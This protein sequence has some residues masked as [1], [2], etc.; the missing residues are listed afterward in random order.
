MIR[1]RRTS[2][3]VAMLAAVSMA[4]AVRAQQMGRAAVRESASRAR[5]PDRGRDLLLG[6][7]SHSIQR[8]RSTPQRE[9]ARSVAGL[10]PLAGRLRTT[11]YRRGAPVVRMEFGEWRS[12]RR[13]EKRDPLWPG[14]PQD[15]LRHQPLRRKRL[16]R[17]ARAVSVLPAQNF[18]GQ[19]CNPLG[20]AFGGGELRN[21]NSSA[22]ILCGGSPSARN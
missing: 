11:R 16:A 12:R 1:G 21:C 15:A 6:P 20:A 3:L 2:L 4:D 13:G 7:T 9:G 17:S 22:M 18:A 8:Y 19:D 14:R 10:R 5:L